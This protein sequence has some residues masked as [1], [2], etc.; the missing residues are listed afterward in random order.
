VDGALATVFEEIESAAANC[1]FLDCSHELEPGCAVRQAIDRGEIEMRRL[2]N[3]QKLLREN[4]RNS[5]S[6]AEKRSEGR[7]FAKHVKRAKAHKANRS[8]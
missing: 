1:R 6:L 8:S 2:L 5:A 4:A 7:A 3:Y